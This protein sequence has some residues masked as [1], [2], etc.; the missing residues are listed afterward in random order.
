VKTDS[1]SDAEMLLDQI[2]SHLRT[3]PV[4]E[5]PAVAEAGGRTSAVRG[6]IQHPWWYVAAAVALAAS[7]AGFLFWRPV[8]IDP[9]RLGNGEVVI[10]QKHD[11]EVPVQQEQPL[12]TSEAAPVTQL[13]VDLQQPLDRLTVG[14]DAVDREIAELRTP[15]AL[16]DAR[17]KADALLAH[18]E[19]NVR[20]DRRHT[21]PY[22]IP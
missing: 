5:M 18:N 3:Q 13:A 15:A 12:P 1:E 20:G 10:E 7:I 21:S 8:G 14:L 9:S 22:S 17:R 19:S 11:P 6:S 4:P 2:A 16:L